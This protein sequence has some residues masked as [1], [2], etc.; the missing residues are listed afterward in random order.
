MI[1]GYKKIKDF[2]PQCKEALQI[3]QLAKNLC[4]NFHFQFNPKFLETFKSESEIFIKDILSEI[5]VLVLYFSHFLF[6]SHILIFI[7]VLPFVN[8]ELFSFKWRNLASM[9]EVQLL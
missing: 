4:L 2:N 8:F 3:L 7:M 6:H 1:L 5:Q 9:V